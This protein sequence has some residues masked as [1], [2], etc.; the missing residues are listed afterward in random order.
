MLCSCNEIFI[1]CGRFPVP[2]S[3]TSSKNS[4]GKC[5]SE[6]VIVYALNYH[7]CFF[8]SL[9]FTHIAAFSFGG[10][11]TTDKASVKWDLAGTWTE[12]AGMVGDIIWKWRPALSPDRRGCQRRQGEEVGTAR[13]YDRRST[14]AWRRWNE[15]V[16]FIPPCCVWFLFSC[17]RLSIWDKPDWCCC[18]CLARL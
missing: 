4:E 14:W 8:L 18:S 16:K 5:F 11:R 9:S 10:S 17:V 12:L 13:C 2:R 7:H 15:P 3:F 6:P 1:I